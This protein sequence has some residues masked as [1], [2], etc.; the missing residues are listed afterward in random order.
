MKVL[1]PSPLHSYTGRSWAD[2]A[3]STLGELLFDLDRQYPGIRFRMIDEQERM[4]RH[5]RF[6]V[7]G[8]QTFDLAL[9]LGPADEVC[10]VQALSGG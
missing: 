5:V 1:I 9:P 7:N 10:I 3:G 6:F 8:E 2:A 4:R